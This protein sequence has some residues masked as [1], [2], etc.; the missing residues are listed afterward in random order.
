MLNF[1]ARTN[2]NASGSGKEKEARE[3]GNYEKYRWFFTSS[4]KLVIG[5]KSAEQ[6]EDIMSEVEDDDVVM[7]TSSPGSPFCVIKNPNKKDLDE[8]AVFTACFSQDWKKGKKKTEVHIFKGE[9]VTKNKGMS[10]GTFGVMGS[11]Q[12]RKVELKLVLD[13]QKG[14]IRALPP[15]SAKKKILVLVPGRFD[16]IQATNKILE[17]IKDKY[18]YPLTRE[19]VMSAIPSD[20]IAVKMR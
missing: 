7:H 19:E 14:K 1:L 9:Q 12:R 8:C 16:K 4:G 2:R 13:F 15:S 3:N 10:M 6:N 20:G 5:G 11:I 18:S 17:F